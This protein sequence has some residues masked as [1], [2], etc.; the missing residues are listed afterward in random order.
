MP[1]R[2]PMRSAFLAF[3]AALLSWG[4]ARAAE[5]P[6]LRLAPSPDP[7]SD[8]V[9]IRPL[10]DADRHYFLA[11]STNPVSG[12][13]AWG[14]ASGVVHPDAVDPRFPARG[15][16]GAP[17]RY[18]RLQPAGLSNGPLYRAF[19]ASPFPS[20]KPPRVLVRRTRRGDPAEAPA[21][22]PLSVV[23][24]SPLDASGVP[25][26][27]QWFASNPGG[28]TNPGA[29]R[30]VR[31]TLSYLYAF[32]RVAPAATN[33]DSGVEAVLPDAVIPVDDTAN[34]V[35]TAGTWAD[36]AQPAGAGR[37]RYS[38]GPGASVEYTVRGARRITW[39][40]F[41]NPT[42]AGR[43]RVEITGPGGPIT[44][45]Q[46]QVG[47]RDGV[48]AANL[49]YVATANGMRYALVPL[50][51]GLDPGSAYTV[52]L[53]QVDGPR[54]FDGGLRLG[55]G[56]A[57]T[58]GYPL[59]VPG[60]HGV[61]DSYTTFTG[62]AASLW[63]GSRV[64]YRTPECTTISWRT[65]QRSNGGRALVRIYGA[66]GTEVPA[67]CYPLPL[68]AVTGAR[69]VDGV[70]PTLP[71]TV[72]LATNLPG[73]RYWVHI[74]SA[75]TTSSTVAET[76]GA[77]FLSSA[78]ALYDA[79]LEVRDTRRP[80]V[81]GSDP[82]LDTPGQ[83]FGGGVVPLDGGG[84]LVMSVQVRD[85]DDPPFLFMPETGFVSSVHGAETWPEGLAVEVDGV[86]QPWGAVPEEAEFTGTRV[87]FRFRTRLGTQRERIREW[88]DVSYRHDFV[89][90]GMDVGYSLVTTRAVRVGT[91]Y[92]NMNSAP[93]LFAYPALALGTRF[94]RLVADPGD[95]FV[96]REMG[97][98]SKV[99][100]GP[101]L[102]S[103]F[104]TDQGHAIAV[105]PLA[106]A[107]SLRPAAPAEYL[108]SYFANRTHT[109]KHYLSVV[110]SL[111]GS[112]DGGQGQPCPKGAGLEGAMR[113]RFTVNPAAAA[114]VP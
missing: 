95:V 103:V 64:V 97:T 45:A 98:E 9:L 48:R 99:F 46:W 15:P 12:N 83:F 11:A 94:R 14:I 84:N 90:G 75:S 82:M 6:S 63:P 77:S 52:R 57:S 18:F 32:D 26:V 44:G 24:W 110:G 5:G 37:V 36:Y 86:P 78:W 89:A 7:A 22:G 27:K 111:D 49:Q 91:V 60:R 51:A 55:V 88:A 65:L 56:D 25:Y 34:R 28:V 31:A 68:D 70:G 4:T 23:V 73:G 67:S 38:T 30:L 107:Q 79:G 54:L 106:F 8:A 81:L 112:P 105:E 47:L 59:D 50:A 61:W 87:S 100:D 20:G 42:V 102:G 1:F 39:R 10:G 72:V 92:A 43:V 29:A 104:F 3:F 58:G 71:R 41:A 17:E 35:E 76:A 19:L 80:G 93:N 33:L 74:A 21:S 109:A 66:D 53:T 85:E 69:V 101:C 2:P 114:S 16:A 62:M 113:V 13:A 96:M 108:R 40:S